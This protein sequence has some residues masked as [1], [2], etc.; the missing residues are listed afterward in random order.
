MCLCALYRLQTDSV[1][2][3]VSECEAVLQTF[4]QALLYLLLHVETGREE[5]E[6]GKGEEEEEER[7]REKEEQI[8]GEGKTGETE[9]GEERGRGEHFYTE[10]LGMVSSKY[11]SSCCSS[12]PL[13][14]MHANRTAS[15]FNGIVTALGH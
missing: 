7:E 4:N 5:G 1:R 9:D 10:V 8:D 14:L 13:G 15:E 12:T 6:G 2:L 11:G 3:S